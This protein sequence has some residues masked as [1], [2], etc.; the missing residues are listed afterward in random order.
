M[1]QVNQ[2]NF[3]SLSTVSV[4]MTMSH[5]I[6]VVL[7][8][9][10]S[11]PHCF[12]HHLVSVV[13]W[14]VESYKKLCNNDNHFFYFSI[15]IIFHKLFLFLIL[16]FIYIFAYLSNAFFLFPFSILYM[17]MFHDSHFLHYF[18]LQYEYFFICFLF[19]SLFFVCFFVLC[20]FLKKE[21]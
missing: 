13:F 19:V 7:T 15:I 2:V 10:Y 1:Q 6:S 12:G 8:A 14:G 16:F 20:V 3:S 9:L 18:E 4:R 11:Y 5:S 17:R 21:K